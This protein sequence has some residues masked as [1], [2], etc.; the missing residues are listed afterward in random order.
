MT[1]AT[2]VRKTKKR[3]ASKKGRRTWGR[4]RRLPSGRWQASY[5]TPD[6]SLRHAPTTFETEGAADTWLANTK[7]DLSRGVWVDPTHNGGGVHFDVW[8]E[9]WLATRVKISPKTR[10]G[11]EALLRNH[12]NPFF[13][14]H[15]LKDVRRATVLRFVTE[16]VTSGAKPGTVRN[17]HSVVSAV[18]R[19]AVED[20]RLTR[21]PASKIDLPEADHEEVIPLTPAEVEAIAQ[22]IE[23]RPENRSR[24]RTEEHHPEWSLLVRFAAYSGL[25]SA[26]IAGMRV[27]RLDLMRG[28]VHVRETVV[29]L[30][31]KLLERQPTKTKQHR[32]V[33]IP[34]GLVDELAR[35]TADRAGDPEAYVFPDIKGGPWREVWWYQHVFKPAVRR[36]GLPDRIRFHDLRH[37]YASRLI[38][39]GESLFTVARQMGHSTTKVT[40]S[41]Y[42]HLFP[43]TLDA[44]ADRLDVTFREHTAAPAQVAQVHQIGRSATA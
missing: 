37:T 17:A 19:H 9:D 24:R 44:L 8:A 31:G 41:R 30:G 6:G 43:S 29:Q 1:D 20:G 35:H 15:A 14:H 38:A 4:T 39:Q 2:P 23:T 11:Y 32:T 42:G 22:A 28:E 34:S 16:M 18:F 25:R 10:A 26:E 3:K 27:G 40:E 5:P 33:R 21:N 13:G 12:I 7:A 36:A